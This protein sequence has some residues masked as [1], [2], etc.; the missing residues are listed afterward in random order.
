MQSIWVATLY[1]YCNM[2]KSRHFYPLEYK[3]YVQRV[4]YLQ[5]QH[6][7]IANASLATI[8][9]EKKKIPSISQSS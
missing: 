2:I 4:L 6:A 1:S 8:K 9:I 3:Q 5:V 7:S